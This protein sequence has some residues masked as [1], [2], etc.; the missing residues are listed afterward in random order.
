MTRG[1]WIGR[2]LTGGALRARPFLSSHPTDEELLAFLDGELDGRAL[3]RIRSHLDGCWPCRGRR[4]R[5]NHV[6]AAFVDVRLDECADR[7]GFPPSA[8]LKLSARLDEVDA[9]ATR[10]SLWRRMFWRARA[11][12]AWRPTPAAIAQACVAALMLAIVVVSIGRDPSV[13]A[14]ELLARTV[15]AQE[16]RLR[17][18]P[19]P[20]VYQRM[21]VSRRAGAAGASG[22]RETQQTW[23]IWSDTVHGRYRERV[24]AFAPIAHRAAPDAE[25]CGVAS[26]SAPASAASAAS[27]PASMSASASASA[28]APASASASASTAA[29]ASTPIGELESILC[30]NGL[31]SAQ[32]LSARAWAEWRGRAR[33]ASERVRENNASD[34]GPAALVLHTRLAGDD[35]P[36]RIREAELVVRADDWH[37]L[38]QR[39]TVEIDRELVTYELREL[40]FEVVELASVAPAFFDD[41]PPPATPATAVAAAAAAVEA[42]SEADVIAA[43][44]QAWEALHRLGALRGEPVEIVRAQASPRVEVRGLASSPERKQAIVDAVSAI[45]LVTAEIRTV[46]EALAADAARPSA[47]RSAAPVVDGSTMVQTGTVPIMPLI[48]AY[49]QG[50]REP[51]FS[52]AD[53]GAPADR[54]RTPDSTGP[55]S[56]G[57]QA[58]QALAPAGTLADHSRT[59]DAAAPASGGAQAL[60]T[61]VVSLSRE[62]MAEAWALERLAR[63]AQGLGASAVRPSSRRALERMASELAAAT[64]AKLDALDQRI[65]PIIAPLLESAPSI[66][67]AAKSGEAA[68]ANAVAAPDAADA[69]DAATVDAAAAAAGSASDWPRLALRVFERA[70]E[71]DETTRRLFTESDAGLVELGPSARQLIAAC[72]SARQDALTLTERLT[73]QRQ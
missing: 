53:A 23:E 44:V 17:P 51:G 10:P 63:F 50:R 60:A 61:D 30:A 9:R 25:A 37:P 1:R 43:E 16:A 2:A 24:G 36:M 39:F 28:A 32:P 12:F 18:V 8:A 67:Q 14:Q 52:Y 4:D 6:I 65:T 64:A 56:G 3:T 35:R 54:K 45:P 26:R 47:D 58:P 41:A 46:E 40:S 49:L 73:S 11:A 15:A 22:W 55:T 42:V 31:R 71:A 48:D 59:R 68:A 5:F 72:T 34:D 20:V 57:S 38:A 13:S 70:R 19:Q 69:A 66:P 21:Q 62:A 7:E 33:G 27:A 29:L